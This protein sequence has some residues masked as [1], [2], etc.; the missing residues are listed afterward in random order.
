VG[1]VDFLFN[2]VEILSAA[3]LGDIF[4]SS[5]EGRAGWGGR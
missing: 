4:G 2:V 1:F 3:W 5:E